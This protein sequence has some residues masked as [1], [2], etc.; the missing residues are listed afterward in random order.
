[1]LLNR[2][3]RKCKPLEQ[4]RA[5]APEKRRRVDLAAGGRIPHTWRPSA[6]NA[7]GAVRFPSGSLLFLR[8]LRRLHHLT[9]SGAGAPRARRSTD[10][11]LS[12]FRPM[13]R[14]CRR[15][16]IECR[17]R[18]A[19]EPRLPHRPCRGATERRRHPSGGADGTQRTPRELGRAY[20]L[21]GP[22]SHQSAI[23][24]GRPHASDR[25]G[26]G[27]DC[28]RCPS[29]DLDNASRCRVLPADRVRESCEPA[30]G[31]RR[32]TSP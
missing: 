32:V 9:A 1:M 22:C 8:F 15:H 12:L 11:D 7:T 13:Q 30:D 19:S 21:V 14:T 27:R 20:R 23:R 2:L 28:W 24:R 16:G 31:P 3:G 5:I 6:S 4:Q 25:A 10:P 18:M 26:A 17:S 29:F